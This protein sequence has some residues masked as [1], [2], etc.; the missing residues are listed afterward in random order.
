MISFQ[1]VALFGKNIY[2]CRY[3]YLQIYL[4]QLTNYDWRQCKS[5]FIQ[6]NFFYMSKINK[7]VFECLKYNKKFR[8]LFNYNFLK[9]NINSTF[10]CINSNKNT[11]KCI[12]TIQ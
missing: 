11:I 4:T 9:R 2:F 1:S 3:L 8:N 5:N 6:K 12:N 7:I 10:Y